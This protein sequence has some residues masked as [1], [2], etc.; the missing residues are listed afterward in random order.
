MPIHHQR[1]L[2]SHIQANEKL[3][4]EEQSSEGAVLLHS[5]R[6]L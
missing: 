4:Q 1:M 2:S 6:Y 5:E 3:R